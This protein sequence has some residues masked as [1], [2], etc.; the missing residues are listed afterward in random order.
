MHQ[1]LPHIEEVFDTV[2]QNKATLFSTLDCASGFWQ[3]P[4]D[5]ATAQ[6]TAFLTQQGVFQFKRL[7]FGLMNASSVFSIVMNHVHRHLSTKYA[8]VYVDDILV[9]RSTFEHL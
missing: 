1:P 9:F 6:K 3:I 7:P 2:G 5:E 8:M 4:L